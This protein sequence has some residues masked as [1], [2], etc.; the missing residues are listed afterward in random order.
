MNFEEMYSILQLERRL[1]IWQALNLTLI[2]E[3]NLCETTTGVNIGAY[4]VTCFENSSYKYMILF[5]MQYNLYV[6]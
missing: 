3:P 6:V 5:L 2:T 4:F 1:E